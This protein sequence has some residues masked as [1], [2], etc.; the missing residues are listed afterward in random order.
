MNQVSVEGI[1]SR[2]VQGHPAS[3][4]SFVDA[5]VDP[6]SVFR[7]PQEVV[8]HPGFTD[9]EKRTILLGQGTSSLW[10]RSSRR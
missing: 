6:V 3:E 4:P 10:N 7:T 8:D 1:S 5:L 2:I 9:S